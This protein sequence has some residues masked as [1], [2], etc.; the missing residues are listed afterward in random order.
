MRRWGI[1]ISL[2]YAL[3]VIGLLVPAAVFLSGGESLFSSSYFGELRSA[4]SAW[5]VWAP[6]VVLI[7]SQ[8]IL[9]FLSVDTS[10]KRLKPRAH[11]AVSCMMAA[12]MVAL[13]TFAAIVSVDA[14]V[15]GPV[16]DAIDTWGKALAL[17]GGL[18]AIWGVVFYLYLRGASGATTRAV[19]WLL[20]GSV[21]ELLIAVS[22]HVIVRRRGDCC[23]PILTSFGIVTGV[24]IMLLSFG[25]SIL[26]LYKKRIDGYRARQNDAAPAN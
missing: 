26:L 5:G 23:A 10:F 1:V 17:C 14:A 21:L 13:L 9:L 6:A 18:W 25:P 8:A 12:L 11:I 2:F 15:K 3:I 16:S 7:A 20:K 4:Y 22:S 19:S 24:A